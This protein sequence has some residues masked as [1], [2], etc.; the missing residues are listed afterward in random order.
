[1][2]L[3]SYAKTNEKYKNARFGIKYKVLLIKSM[4]LFDFCYVRSVLTEGQ[5]QN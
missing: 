3:F 1:M 4:V 5:G 2:D